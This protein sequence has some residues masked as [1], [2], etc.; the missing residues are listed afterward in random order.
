MLF[1]SFDFLV[2][3]I[4]VLLVFWAASGRPVV[5]VVFLLGASYFFYMA[6]PKF[7]PPGTPWYYAGLLLFSTALD[8]ACGHAM[9]RHAEA[10]KS[11][12][13]T[14]SGPAR[15]SSGSSRRAMACVGE[16]ANDSAGCPTKPLC[17]T[18][19]TWA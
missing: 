6:G 3:I 5:R 15:R 12:D 1:P 17:C 18:P 14:V 10:A 16:S 13:P 7:D 8:F 19:A 2:F 4:P 9:A 11:S